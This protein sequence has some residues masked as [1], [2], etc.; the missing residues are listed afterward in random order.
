MS[1]AAGL[2]LVALVGGVGLIP[3]A[4]PAPLQHDAPVILVESITATAKLA[5]DTGAGGTAA[6]AAMAR[7]N[8]ELLPQMALKRYH[9]DVQNYT[10]TFWKQERIGDKLGQVERIAV[11]YREAPVSV[12]M[13]WE[14]N[15]TEVKRALFVDAPEYVDNQG[16]KVAKIEPNGAIVRLLISEVTLPIHGARARAASRNPMDQF[17]FRRALELLLADNA[18]SRQA[19][20]LDLRYD[21]ESE[22]DGRPTYVLVRY[23]PY[24]GDGSKYPNAKMIMHIDQEWMIPTAV[25]G[26]ADKQAATLLCSYVYTGVKINPGLTD[27][28]FEF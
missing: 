5:A 24:E 6:Y 15:A 7:R 25:Y 28:D 14:Q 1:L 19:G 12:F 22:V 27:Q 4:E 2:V 21:G 16:R 18:R 13:R 11:S 10:C 23:L 20:D 8:P 9:Q 17:G 26:Y 3:A